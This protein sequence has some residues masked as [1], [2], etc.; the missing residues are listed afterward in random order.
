MSVSVNYRAT[1]T[2]H[3][4]GT[5]DT[6]DCFLFSPMSSFL[7]DWSKEHRWFCIVYELVVSEKKKKIYN[8]FTY[9]THFKCKIKCIFPY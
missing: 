8:F 1:Y 2:N 7:Q 9:F 6:D 3:V 4:S 5:K